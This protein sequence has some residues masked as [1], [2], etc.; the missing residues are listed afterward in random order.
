MVC[1]ITQWKSRRKKMSKGQLINVYG[2]A[3]EPQRIDVNEIVFIPHVCNDL[4]GWGAGFVLALTKMSSF[5]EYMYKR[6]FQ[7]FPDQEK[8]GITCF[9][10]IPDNKT[11]TVCNMIAQ[12]G[13]KSEHNLRP[14]NYPVLIKCMTDVAEWIQEKMEMCEV[15]EVTIPPH[16]IHCPKFGGDLAGGNWNFITCLIEDIWLAAGIDVVVYEWEQDREKWGPIED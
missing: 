10:P 11:I 8:R 14:L 9:A 16:R 4:G 3:T 12:S 2:D 1:H 5:P 13:Y 15:T 7:R 6:T